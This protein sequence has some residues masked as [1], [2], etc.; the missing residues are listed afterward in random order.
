[1][2][3]YGENKIDFTRPWKRLTMREA[4]IHYWPD[5]EP[6][7]RGSELTRPRILLD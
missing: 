6:T 3:E 1:M 4:V 2:L 7:N 5:Q